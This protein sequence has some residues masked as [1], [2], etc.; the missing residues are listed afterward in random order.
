MDGSKRSGHSNAYFSGLVKQKGIALYDTLLQNQSNEEILAVI[1]HE[2]GHY[3]CKHIQKY[4]NW[5]YPVWH[6]SFYVVFFEKF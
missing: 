3:K 6:Y 5:S 4:Y 2:V 1:A